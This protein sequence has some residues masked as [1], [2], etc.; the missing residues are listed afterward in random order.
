M[1]NKYLE[2]YGE[3]LLKIFAKKLKGKS[4]EEIAKTPI[5]DVIPQTSPELSILKENIDRIF[6]REKQPSKTTKITQNKN[7]KNQT[8]C[9]SKDLTNDINDDEKFSISWL[10]RKF[11]IGYVKAAQITDNLIEQKIVQKNECGYTILD[12][13]KLKQELAK[14]FG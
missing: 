5:G 7:F 3:Q 6:D 2:E 12:I 14:I 1:D 10:Q 13:E 9:T 11:T 4:L 8:V